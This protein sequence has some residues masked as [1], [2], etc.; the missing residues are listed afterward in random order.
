MIPH[1]FTE[2]QWLDWAAQHEN[3]FGNG[4]HDPESQKRFLTEWYFSK[5][6]RS[7]A[8][9][10]SEE[11][12]SVLHEVKTFVPG[13]RLPRFL[14]HIYQGRPDLQK[15]FPR[16]DPKTPTKLMQWYESYGQHELNAAHLISAAY[17][18]PHKAAKVAVEGSPRSR[19]LAK[20]RQDIGFGVNLIGYA[21]GEFGLGEDIRTLAKCIEAAEIEYCVFNL[22]N[23]S[24]ARLHDHT[25]D[26]KFATAPPYPVS[27][28][29]V[30][31]FDIP[32]IAQ[33]FGNQVFNEKYV[34]AYSPWELEVFPR[35]WA[36][37]LG[38][39]DELWG[40]SEHVSKAYQN[41]T[42]TPC[43]YMPP[44]VNV[45]GQAKSKVRSETDTFRFICSYDP[46]S[47]VTRKNPQAAI[48][49]F[50]LA[51][52]DKSIH[53]SLLF[54]VNGS[55][56]E[57]KFTQNLQKISKDDPR[58]RYN[59]GTHDRSAY[60][61]LLSSA[62]C[63]LSPHRAEGFGRN[64]A[65]AKALGVCVLSTGYSGAR[66]FLDPDEEVSWQYTTVGQAGYIYSEGALWAEID[67]SDLAQKMK[68][69]YS[70]RMQIKQKGLSEVFS[71]REAAAR[72]RERLQHI[73][74]TQFE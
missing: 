24:N 74:T 46:N 19:I 32:R 4:I 64:I 13:L 36:P 42:R 72:Y 73:N 8:V 12:I 18:G 28:L 15:A 9:P 70:N 25:L 50:L 21:Q 26:E 62:D 17:S 49:G 43:I 29:C 47:F 66:D 41:A 58:I 31:P 69:L 56:A 5:I 48:E 3:R 35:E 55:N 54:L 34:I 68:N 30:S 65:E 7:S 2:E 61:A 14:Q 10:L 63:F 71:I 53:A 6:G 37:A 33:E 52:P 1:F 51:F 40:I 22:P 23:G 16:Q 59:I 45:N 20:L 11:S 39:V 38:W 44:A 67:T 27:I 60:L 57:D